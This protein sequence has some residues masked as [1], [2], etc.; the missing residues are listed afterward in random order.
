MIKTIVLS[1]CLAVSSLS[2]AR[3]QSGPAHAYGPVT[4]VDYI[5]LNYG[6]FESVRAIPHRQRSSA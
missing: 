6:H 3:A 2:L 1:M 4:E 5:H